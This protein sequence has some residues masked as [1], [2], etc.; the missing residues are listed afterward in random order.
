MFFLDQSKNSSR[1]RCQTTLLEDDHNEQKLNQNHKYT[2]CKQQMV[3][4]G[5]E[6]CFIYI[7]HGFHLEEILFDND[8]WCYLKSL[9]TRFCTEIYLPSILQ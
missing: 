5:T 7:S 6:K 9:F 3:I 2:K 4:T 1:P 8:Y